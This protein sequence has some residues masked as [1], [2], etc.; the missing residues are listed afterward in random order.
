LYFRPLS[1]TKVTVK[2]NRLEADGRKRLF[3]ECV[4]EED[5]VIGEGLHRRTILKRTGEIA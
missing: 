4:M 5:K 2:S 3:E 1:K